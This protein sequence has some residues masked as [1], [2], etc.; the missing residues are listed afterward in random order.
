MENSE[1]FIWKIDRINFTLKTTLSQNM[2]TK[3]NRTPIATRECRQDVSDFCYRGPLVFPKIVEPF[4][5]SFRYFNDLY[6]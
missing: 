6:V 1:P 3:Y 2:T 5:N 4:T